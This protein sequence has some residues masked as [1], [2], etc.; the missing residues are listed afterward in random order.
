MKRTRRTDIRSTEIRVLKFLFTMAL[1]VAAGVMLFATPDAPAVV[2]SALMGVIGIS[3]MSSVSFCDTGY[4]LPTGDAQL[5]ASVPETLASIAGDLKTV[6]G[7]TLIQVLP[8]AA[9]MQKEFPLADSADYPLVGDYFSA[10]IGLQFPW[11]FSFLGQGNENTATNTNLGDALA[12]QTQPAKIYPC[13]TVLTD[14][15][16]YQIL[17]R[18][19]SSNSKQAVLSALSYTGKQ[20]A[21]IM[22]NVL[23]LQV[24]H[25]RDGIGVVTSQTGAGPFT[26]VLDPA[27]TSP[28]ILSLLIGARLQVMQTNNTT[29][30]TANSTANYLTVTAIS[31]A[32][33]LN[34]SV[35][36]TAT[37]ATGV[38]SVVATDIIYIAGTRGISV[39]IGDTAVPQYEQIGL[40]QQLNA[41]TGVQFSIDKGV[42]I[43]WV[44]NQIPA[45]GAFS[46][47][48]LMQAAQKSMSRG[49]ELGAYLAVCSPA[50]WAVLNSALA[51]N[52]TYNQ[53]A[54]SSAMS[55]KTGTDEIVIKHGGITIEVMSHPLQ[56]DG[57]FYLVPRNNVKR[58]GST[59]LTFAVPG[60]P[61]G[62]EYMYPLPGQAIMQRQCRADWQ[63]VLLTPPSGCIG[64]G[65]TFV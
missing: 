40:G 29:A 51:T 26:L 55:K 53:Q 2:H 41:T 30:R 57:Q 63:V 5:G 62:D 15:L 46:P 16:A 61:E 60:R 43:G 49:G 28:G 58:I 22:R 3:L 35:T 8:D 36:V 9:M 42:Y 13:T 25:G 19:N 14:N 12:G 21:I 59:D 20:M 27:T 31:L 37:G 4:S 24:L 44:A 56:K 64:T 33:P 47:S 11:G 6:Y 32:D 52:E 17:D 65:I 54:P 23:E 39:S 34:P 1:A 48:V 50:Q 38:G 10:L 7:N 18:A 45:I